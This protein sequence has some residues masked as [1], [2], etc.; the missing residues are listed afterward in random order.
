MLTAGILASARSRFAAAFLALAA[1]AALLQPADWIALWNAKL[2]D[3][4][5]TFWR[6]AAPE[7]VQRDVVVIGIDVEDLREF[8]DPRDFWHPHYGRLL[9]ALAQAKPAVV[10]LDIVLPERSYQQLIP[11]LDQS[12][13]KGLVA[14]RAGNVP[15]VLARTV[16]DFSNFREIFAPYVA[17]VGPEAVGSVVVCKDDDE[18]VRRFDEYL[19]DSGRDKA[20]PSLAGLMA[21]RLGVKGD[22]RGWIDYRIGAPIDYVR[23]RDVVHWAETRDPK[24][25]AT[26][27]GRPVLLGFILPFEDRRTVPVD[28]ARWEPGNT[29]VPGVLVHAQ[30]LRTML[31]GGLLRAMPGWI[32]FVVALAGAAFVF[33]HSGARTF[34]L[35]GGYLV[36]LG[37]GMLLSLRAGWFFEAAV[38][39]LVGSV[40]TAGRFVNDAV[41][42][43]RE[44]AT[45]RNAFGGYVSPQIMHEILAG[46]IAPGLGGRRER[47]CL[48]FSDVRDFTTRSEFMAP[49]ALIDM[50]NRYFSEM[51]RCVHEQG[52]TVDKFIGDGM[53][54]FFGAP[55]PLANP[56]ASAV[57]A[58]VEMLE[59]LDHLNAAFVEL[60]LPPL[61]IGIG[62]HIGEV[63]V[64]HV[65]SDDRHEYTVI[66][67]A[68]NTASRIE[69]LTKS[70]GNPLVVSKDVWAELPDQDKFTAL[71]EHPVKGRSSVQVYGYTGRTPQG[72]SL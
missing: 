50:L 21:L 43:A 57:A 55:Q 24:L 16:D 41:A 58:A 33:L 5:F 14:T 7:P 8:K 36:A 54:C 12:L 63:V 49:E 1:A 34:A 9:T 61:R 60:D 29:S 22:W 19:C 26:F 52:G 6:R 27:E 65:G 56:A 42:H 71:G 30:V 64:G 18:V 47:V 51:T 67:D 40:A 4:G 13:L 20:L 3:A 23:F 39:I 72:E 66:G 37:A 53:M 28:L 45:L 25:A 68:V 48:L 46:R 10:G 70:L 62:L 44:R 31:N 69:G 2:L 17:L 32:A 11:G 59:R 35:Y 38:P 15:V